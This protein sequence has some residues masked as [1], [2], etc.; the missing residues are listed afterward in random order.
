MKNS[1]VPLPQT[2]L[3]VRSARFTLIELLVV[4]AIIAILAAMLLPALQ[5]A[6]KKARTISCANNLKTMGIAVAAYSQDNGG[7]V[8]P[9]E[10]NEG[11]TTKMAITYYHKY[12]VQFGV[13]EDWVA[14]PSENWDENRKKAAFLSC[15]EGVEAKKR[16]IWYGANVYAASS[17]HA[18]TNIKDSTANKKFFKLEQ[19]KRP[20]MLMNWV[21]AG[22]RLTNLYSTY[23]SIYYQNP[24]SG[25][26][27]EYRHGNMQA[28]L[29][30]F[31]SHVATLTYA[32]LGPDPYN[33]GIR[34]WWSF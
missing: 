18:P 8:V 1:N 25:Y 22:Y 6:R 34:R 21:D 12:F 29:L 11:G 17:V 13:A 32:Q 27:P 5:Q 2:A 30:L 7:Y 24:A 19:V 3:T 23:Q 4:I 26:A 20:T 28:N 10:Y 16:G 14:S 15:P 9:A 33:G 31:D